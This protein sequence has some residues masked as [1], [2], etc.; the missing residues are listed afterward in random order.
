MPPKVHCTAQDESW[1]DEE[2]QNDLRSL[3][4]DLDTDGSNVL[5]ESEREEHSAMLTS[6]MTRFHLTAD[7]FQGAPRPPLSPSP[8]KGYAWFAAR[9]LCSGGIMASAVKRTL[10][11]P[12]S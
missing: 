10:C 12:L 8:C 11:K 3:F 2:E 1:M 6:F 5:E 9:D 4:A 7:T